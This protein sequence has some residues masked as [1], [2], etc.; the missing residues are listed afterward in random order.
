MLMMRVLLFTDPYFNVVF[1]YIKRY[2]T[3]N[4]RETCLQEYASELHCFSPYKEMQ[5]FP[6]FEVMFD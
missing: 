5:W 3:K 6:L 1:L 2:L 4:E